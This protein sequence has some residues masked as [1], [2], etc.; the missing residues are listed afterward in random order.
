MYPEKRII[1][2][3][4]C[5]GLPQLHGLFY[6]TTKMTLGIDHFKRSET[7]MK[8]SGNSLNAIVTGNPPTTKRT[9][10]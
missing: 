7:V 5:S 8:H 10:N 6:C 4:L 9:F 2:M 3:E 1:I